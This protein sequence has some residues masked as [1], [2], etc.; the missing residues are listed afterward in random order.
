MTAADRAA[1]DAGVDGTSRGAVRGWLL[2]GS[3]YFLA[4]FHR[5][6]LGVAGLLAERR[7][8]IDA[9]QLGV[10][11]LLQIGVYA[12]MQVPTGVLVDRYGPRRLLVIASTL[13][14]VAQLGFALAPSYPVALLARAA[15]GAGDAMTFISVLRFAA[16]HFSPRRYPV[17]VALT[18]TLGIVGNVLATL[19]LALLLNSAGWAPSFVGAAALSLVAAGVLVV[20]LDD[21]TARPAPISTRADLGRGIASVAGRLRAAIGLPGTRLGFWVHFA[22]MSTATSLSVLWGHPY[23]VEGVG[24]SDTAASAVLMAGVVT[25]GICGPLIGWGI[26]RRPA[27]R[28]PIALTACAVSIVGWVVVIAA[29]GDTPPAAVVC[30]VFVLS[31]IGSPVS[32]VAFAVTR[33]YNRA[34]TIGTASG[35]VNVGGFLAAVVVCLCFGWTL[36]ALGGSSPHDL[37]LAMLVMVVVQT[38]GSAR[39]AAWYRRTR[40]AV[41]VRQAAGERVPVR[42]ER[43]YWWDLPDLPCAAAEAQVADARG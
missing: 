41:R 4:V 1:P 9:G 24:L 32:M 36:N 35:A 30:P 22:C 7:F 17:I 42:V 13:M 43:L 31:M 25:S 3:V 14:G 18:G 6:S 10:F 16:R 21:D 26:G 5:S 11:V 38:F 34:Q 8:G 27:L 28:V 39:V 2:A 37:R 23:L 29:C 19:P 15:L 12:V 40:A 20:L 33:D